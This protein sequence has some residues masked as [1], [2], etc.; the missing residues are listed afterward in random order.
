MQSPLQRLYK[1][2]FVLVST[3][4]TVFGSALLFAAHWVATQSI[5]P[6]LQGFPVRDFGAV[7]LTSG[8]VVVGFTYADHEDEERRESERL[9]RT[10]REEAPAFRDAVSLFQPQCDVA[11]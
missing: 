3:I 7:F 10:L 4:A 6:A 1:T 9:H 5:L 11:R 8:V 2:K